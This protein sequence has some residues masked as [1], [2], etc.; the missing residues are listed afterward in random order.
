M[1]NFWTVFWVVVG[2]TVLLVFIGIYNTFQ[3]VRLN[4]EKARSNIKVSLKQRFDEIPQLV[5]VCSQFLEKES[6]L[7]EE[8]TRLRS[9]FYEKTDQDDAKVIRSIDELNKSLTGSLEK[10]DAVT[11]NYPQ[12]L[13]SQQ[14]LALMGRISSLEE[15][16]SHRREYYNESASIYN[17]RLVSFPDFIFAAVLGYR[18]L[19]FLEVPEP[20]LQVPEIN[21]IKNPPVTPSPPP[22]MEVYFPS[23]T[24]APA[25]PETTDPP[26]TP[27]PPASKS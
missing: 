5:K 24:L 22:S 6:Q 12:L 13:A 2:I 18:P 16:I 11:E 8:L 23:Q 7:L 4:V 25:A 1:I 17:S 3:R 21:L 19:E 20:E 14:F 27:A 9:K 26:E 15:K 10:L